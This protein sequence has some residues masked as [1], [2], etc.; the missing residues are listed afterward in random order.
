M[1]ITITNREMEQQNKESPTEIFIRKAKAVHGNTYDYSKVNYRGKD[2][3]VTIIC[4]I[5]GEFS[6]IASDHVNNKSGCPICNESA[7]GSV[8]K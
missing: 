5:H 1:K 2:K 3:N 6:Q 8:P 4:P 7:V